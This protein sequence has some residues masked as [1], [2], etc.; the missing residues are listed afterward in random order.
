MKLLEYGKHLD[1]LT[2]K[3]KIES[4]AEKVRTEERFSAVCNHC[5]AYI[6]MLAIDHFQTHHDDWCQMLRSGSWTELIDL[7]NE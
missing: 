2:A 4:I 7:T 3:E 1:T 6:V 5:D